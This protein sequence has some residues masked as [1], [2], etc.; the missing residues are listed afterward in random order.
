MFF[1]IIP[2]SKTVEMKIIKLLFVAL[3]CLILASCSDD[4]S[5]NNETVKDEVSG[6]IIV[7]EDEI[8]DKE[9]VFDFAFVSSN[10]YIIL[11]SEFDKNIGKGEAYNP[12]S[13]ADQR[14]SAIKDVDTELLE[15]DFA[16]LVGKRVLVGST[17][18]D[19][20]IAE[21]SSIKIMAECIPHFGSLQTWENY[22]GDGKVYTDDEIA[23][24]IWSMGDFYLVAEFE[25]EEPISE[26]IVFAMSL[27]AK[28][29]IF[30]ETE[31]VDIEKVDE[32]ILASL[33]FTKMFQNYQQE[34]E[35]LEYD[36]TQKWWESEE[37]YK[38][39][40][41]IPVENDL[42]VAYYFVA[43][44]PC[45]GDYFFSSFSISNF[46]SDGLFETVYLTDEMYTLVLA[47]DINYDGVLEY[48]VQ[49]FYGR[50][51]LLFWGE[52]DWENM[53]EWSIPYL[54]CPC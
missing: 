12:I 44:S 1:E 18:G 47:L 38:I 37:T 15:A 14:Y 6:E 36:E 25:P 41:Y 30:P 32:K 39:A 26:D 31:F 40:A 33:S 8:I 46:R 54:D 4:T 50:R 35:D 16:D 2:T 13:Y 22:M 53:Y 34:Y 10:K 17:S 11:E 20:V 19:I 28:P 21:I 51:V 7:E 42:Q 24:D 45:G 52:P 23:A 27:D 43:G 49:D 48:I 5:E 29:K 3:S 9:F